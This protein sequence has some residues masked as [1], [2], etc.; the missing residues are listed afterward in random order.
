MLERENTMSYLD[1]WVAAVPNENKEKYLEHAKRA[2]KVFKKHGALTYVENRGD[3][4]AEV[5]KLLTVFY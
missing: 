3:Q 5:I 2:A 1:G 4:V